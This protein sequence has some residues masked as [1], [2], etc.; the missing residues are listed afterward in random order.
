M[1]AGRRVVV[2]GLIAAIIVCTMVAAVWWT[3]EARSQS[4]IDSCLDRGGA[5]DYDAG[6]CQIE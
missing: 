5:W 2:A 1:S 3:D 4:R 6:V